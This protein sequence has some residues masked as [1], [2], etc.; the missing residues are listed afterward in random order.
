MTFK[1]VFLLVPA[2][3]LLQ[4]CSD[5]LDH[6]FQ[7]GIDAQA[8]AVAANTPSQAVF[9]PGGDDPAIPFPS[10]L[11]F[12]GSTDGTV[13]IPVD[14]DTNLADPSVA[15]N[16]LDGFSTISPIVTPMNSQ[17][18]PDTVVVG[19]TIRIFEVEADVATGFASTGF[20]AELGAQDMVAVATADSLILQPTQPLAPNTTFLVLLTDGLQ[21]TDGAALGRSLTYGLL[22]GETDLT[23]APLDTLQAIT[24]SNLAIGEAV[25]VP[26][27]SVVLSFSFNT[28]SIRETLQAVSDATTTQPFT[29]VSVPNTTTATLAAGAGGRADIYIG[30]LDIPY[31]QTAVGDGGASD[32]LD[33]FWTGPEGSFLTQGNPLPVV[34]STQTIPVLMSVPNADSQS[35]GVMPDAGWPVA[36]FLH[37]I[38]Q[39]RTNLVAI[40]DAM[41]DVGF[42]VV[43]IDLP[44]HGI[45]DETNP[46]NATLTVFPNDTERHFNIDIQN[47][48]DA[49]DTEPDGVIDSSGAHYIQLT[50]LANSRDNLRQG[51]SDLL[52]LSA[53]L[54]DLQM[55]NPEDTPVSFD[56]SRK[57]FIGHSLGAITGSIFL[58]FDPTIGSATLAN[59]GSGIAQLLAN[60]DT[61]GPAINAGLAAM[62]APQGSAAN[63]Q[64]LLATQTVIDSGD[65]ANHAGA[66]AQLGTPIHLV[67]V[68]GDEVIPNA[69][70]GAPFSGTEP[71]AALL[72]LQPVTATTN[73]GGLV[74]FSAGSHS[75]ILSPEASP[76]ATVEIQTQM[77]TFAAS[78]GTM[79]P[80]TDSSVIDGAEATGEN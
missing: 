25:G 55:A 78:R 67:E 10:T 74:R 56:V 47:N 39:D 32:A 40:A 46:L 76:A 3:L 60:S 20:I 48:E 15:L 13:N 28:Q 34:T 19:D 16:Q 50:N 7:P 29:A 35:G 37:G 31:Y 58:S 64:F 11:L 57:A 69:V 68:L 52:T 18:N 17:L 75:S 36:I 41:A 43:G 72:G 66:L 1:P 27:D 44:V 54:G 33:S 26:S 71:M 77:A 65:P 8:A 12:A 59:P 24:R 62:G 73:G 2:A 30:T 45:T 5:D 9:N 6:D 42:A 22:A 70:D 4:A 14:D 21:D 51:V 23:V 53:S 63:A 80:I 49:L 79:L 38:T 61:F